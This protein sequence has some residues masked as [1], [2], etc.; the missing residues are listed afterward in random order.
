MTES[1]TV[2]KFH[3][4]ACFDPD[5][6]EELCVEI[7]EHRAEWELAR[8]LEAMGL[9]LSTL[10]KLTVHAPNSDIATPI[11]KLIDTAEKIGMTTL[12]RVACDVR[13]CLNSGGEAAL[14][15]TLARLQRVGEKSI[16]DTCEID[17]VS[18]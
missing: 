2:L 7:G 10:N 15:A 14:A 5:R 6:L 16:Y 18:R 13:N 1:V 17:G 11:G 3:E 9:Y 12:A 8:G 4:G